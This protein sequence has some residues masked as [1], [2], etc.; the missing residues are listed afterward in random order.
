MNE[1]IDKMAL[2]W[3]TLSFGMNLINMRGTFVVIICS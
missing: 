2:F 1:T 3:N